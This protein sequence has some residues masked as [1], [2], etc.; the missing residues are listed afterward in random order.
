MSTAVRRFLIGLW[1]VVASLA[2]CKLWFWV[3]YSSG[4][5]FT[6]P[7]PFAVW[8]TDLYGARNAE[9]VADVE[10]LLVF[11]ICF[12]VV[13]LCTWTALRFTDRNQR[14]GAAPR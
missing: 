8:I 10:T 3:A 13:A 9:E 4:A 14:R 1:I 6:F 2:L 11:G 5:G 12:V 7:E